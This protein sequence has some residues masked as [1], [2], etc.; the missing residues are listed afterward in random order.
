MAWGLEVRVPFLDK[1]FIDVSLPIHPQLKKKNKIEKYIL[2]KAFDRNDYHYLPE[3]IL[4]RQKEQFSDGVGYSWIDSIKQHAV[5][6]ISDELYEEIKSMRPDVTNREEA[7]Y[8]KVFNEKFPVK[9]EFVR[10]WVPKM[11]WEGVSYDPSGRAQKIHIDAN[12]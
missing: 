4:W 3:S 8:T 7:Y 1:D 2:R 9:N 10:R 12:Q 11:S 5:S 6:S